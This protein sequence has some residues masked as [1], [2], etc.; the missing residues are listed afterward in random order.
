M[1]QMD[2]IVTQILDIHQAQAQR[3]IKSSASE[4]VKEA[5][6]TSWSELN[7]GSVDIA[8]TS[9]KIN[10]NVD[11]LRA[12]VSKWIK[13]FEVCRDVE[14]ANF[15]RIDEPTFDEKIR[16]INLQIDIDHIIYTYKRLQARLNVVETEFANAARAF[17]SPLKQALNDINQLYND[18]HQIDGDFTG[19]KNVSVYI[20]GI[21]SDGD[22]FLESSMKA[23]N[24]GDVIVHEKRNGT[25]EYYFVLEGRRGKEISR[26]F[27]S[28]DQL[29]AHK[30]FK[31]GKGRLHLVYDTEYKNEHRQK[32]SDDLAEKLIDMGLLNEETK[33]DLF[34]H[35]YGGRR[36]LQFATDYP[37]NVRSLTT[38]GTPY[39]KNLLGKAANYG[40]KLSPKVTDIFNKEPTEF[41]DYL[42]FNEKNAR[43]DDG[44]THSNVYTD[45]TS[46]AMVDMID[47]VKAANPE[48]YKKLLN[49]EITAAAGRDTNV[50]TYYSEFTGSEQ[51]VVV[52]H[53]D[54]GAVSVKSQHGNSLGD[55]V[56]K[57]PTFDVKGYGITDPA[58]VHQIKD[59]DFIELIKDVNE[60]Q[61]K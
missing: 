20:H 36:S 24:P 45:M 13:D 1:Y 33:I 9:P 58:H 14:V 39:D 41:S 52:P 56:D 21:E 2:P 44:V 3:F 26:A 15:N 23:S 31:H 30:E 38:I 34:A 18:V 7:Y 12:S 48:V 55:L 60:K 22:D 53:K 32:T 50:H 17:R 43:T 11:D 8:L 42:D 10:V 4:L 27:S 25:I 47:Q 37:E 51:K 61:K 59:A 35:S 5:F 16:L 28:F 29:Q 54:D 46:V 49:M 57:R 40:S 19:Y 6:C